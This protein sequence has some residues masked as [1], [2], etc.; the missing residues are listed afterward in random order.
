V[1]L[2]GTGSST[3]RNRWPEKWLKKSGAVLAPLPAFMEKDLPRHEQAYRKW[4]T[5]ESLRGPHWLASYELTI[6]KWVN[7]P[8]TGSHISGDAVFAF[9]RQQNVSF[10]D[11]KLIQKIAGVKEE[12]EEVAYPG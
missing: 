12:L 3:V 10:Y 2:I 9:L 11:E 1:S 4:F 5:T 6:K 7:I 8:P